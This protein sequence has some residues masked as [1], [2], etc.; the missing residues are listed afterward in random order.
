MNDIYNLSRFTEA[1]RRD[2]ALALREI[3]RGRKRSHWM[4]YIFHQLGGL[5]RS[6]TAERYAI[7]GLEEAKAFL[8]DPCLGGNLR[9]ICSAL[10]ELES[11]DPV[12]VFGG[13]TDAMKLR[14]SMTLFACAA[15]GEDIFRRVLDKF[16][17][18]RMDGRTL[19]YLGL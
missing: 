7:S 4:W 17:G 5:G 13:H 2:Y 1:H 8:A 12:E 16:F 9:Q 19:G 10:L 3:R 14:S 6:A 11:S 18:G 15:E